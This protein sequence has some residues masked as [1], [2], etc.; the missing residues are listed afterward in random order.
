MP[1]PVGDLVQNQK[2]VAVAPTATMA[3]ALNLMIEH[4]FSQLPVV[5]SRYKPLGVVTSTSI[6]RALLRFGATVADLNVSDATVK[7]PGYP[8]DEDLLYILDNMLQ[9]SA[10]FILNTSQQL[11]GILTE[12]DTTQ[13]FRQRAEDIVLVEDIESTLKTHLLTAYDSTEKESQALRSAIDSLSNSFDDIRKKGQSCLKAFAKNNEITSPK[14]SIDAYIDKYFPVRDQPKV[15]K[16]LTLS[17]FIQLA[18][19]DYNDGGGSAH[20]E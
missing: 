15:F 18:H 8:A 20:S 9:N 10:V 2:I 3:E 14:T 6:S 11:I 7:I 17:E 1:I 19:K 4:D 13:Y 5:D 16:D 12:F